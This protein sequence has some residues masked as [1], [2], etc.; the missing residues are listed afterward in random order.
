MSDAQI[1]AAARNL[2]TTAKIDQFS[3]IL[4]GAVAPEGEPREALAALV[5][6]ARDREAEAE[7]HTKLLEEQR[8][9]ILD[10]EDQLE[11]ASP[12]NKP[13]NSPPGVEYVSEL[14]DMV[15]LL[16]AEN[17][18][19]LDKAQS[20]RKALKEAQ[21]ELAKTQEALDASRTE[22]E[23]A[24]Q[25]LVMARDEQARLRKT[26]TTKEQHI[27][28]LEEELVVIDEELREAR[29]EGAVTASAVF[30]AKASGQP[31]SSLASTPATTP[32]Q[33]PMKAPPELDVQSGGSSDDDSDAEHL[34]SPG[35]DALGA[36]GCASP[37]VLMEKLD[38]SDDESEDERMAAPVAH[39][40]VPA[41]PPDSPDDDHVDFRSTMSA[42]IAAARAAAGRG[43]GTNGRMRPIRDRRGPFR[44]SITVARSP[45]ASPGG[46]DMEEED[47]LWKRAK[48]PPPAYVSAAPRIVNTSRE[49][50]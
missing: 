27:E 8:A 50:F 26:L 12:N 45:P 10:M 22:A 29:S 30:A 11:Q 25:D 37:A 41:P 42:R 2:E 4:F 36:V 46:I 35:P 23:R 39:R 9:Q 38:V 3:S 1:E 21:A 31:L 34:L 48:S 17:Q 18:K 6:Y 28:E 15:E 33:T 19:L 13:P 44:K 47:G 5:T 16:E 14:E 20:R 7:R 32:A 24:K 43:V 40:P 49:H